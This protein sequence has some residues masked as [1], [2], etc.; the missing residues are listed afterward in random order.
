[1]TI[2]KPKNS[3]QV[4]FDRI[5]TV[6]HVGPDQTLSFSKESCKKL[7]K[8]DEH[9]INMQSLP[10]QI[11]TKVN[12]EKEVECLL[13]I[14]LDSGCS[15]ERHQGSLEQARINEIWGSLCSNPQLKQGYTFEKTDS[16]ISSKH[17]MTVEHSYT[18]SNEIQN[19][20]EIHHRSIDHAMNALKLSQEFDLQ[21]EL[22]F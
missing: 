16:S 1:M 17:E 22:E 3:K 18:P 19:Q 6:A 14:S 15:Y 10:E 9:D 2:S 7:T 20:V 4:C 8:E 21:F 5:T 13:Q 12:R 11:E